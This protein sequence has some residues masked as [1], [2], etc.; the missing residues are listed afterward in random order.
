MVVENSCSPKCSSSD[1]FIIF[2]RNNKIFSNKK[3]SIKTLE[4]LEKLNFIFLLLSKIK[5][6]FKKIYYGFKS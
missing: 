6:L 4:N 1:I 3:I 2:E 5:R